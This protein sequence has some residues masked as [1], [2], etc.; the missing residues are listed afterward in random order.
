M[1]ALHN[2]K[3]IS[4]RMQDVFNAFTA[5]HITWDKLHTRQASAD[6][7]HK[8]QTRKKEHGK[9]AGAS[10]MW[11]WVFRRNTSYHNEFIKATTA[12][13][14]RS[15][16]GPIP[17]LS[18]VQG[19]EALAKPFSAVACK[20]KHCSQASSVYWQ[21]EENAASNERTFYWK[22]VLEK[23]HSCTEQLVPLPFVCGTEQ[24]P[25]LWS[26]LSIHCHPH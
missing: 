17:L 16:E 24:S 11:L 14:L 19:N 12:F 25:V 5:W 20:I 23:W 6:E 2:G 22:A 15:S 9:S 26:W 21:R 8:R 10:R 3:Y 18:P 7:K 1:E 4:S 13:M